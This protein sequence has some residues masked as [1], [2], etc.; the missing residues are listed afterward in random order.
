MDKISKIES[1]YSI[2]P[3]F[4]NVS[5]ISLPSEFEKIYSINNSPEV[6]LMLQRY[7]RQALKL[8]VFEN[9]K[10]ECVDQIKAN[11]ELYEFFQSSI[12]FYSLYYASLL[13]SFVFLQNAVVIQ[14]E[15]LPWQKSQVLDPKAKI[16]S[17][18]NFLQLANE[19]LKVISDYMKVNSSEFPCYN[20]PE[21]DRI[22]QSRSSG[23]YLV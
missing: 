15:E 18:K 9:I 3:F 13:P 23:I 5:Y 1:L 21:P 17:G 7:L 22:P 11:P 6:F 12:V 16:Q 20:S 2:I 8:K 14:Y 4:A 10:S 19:S